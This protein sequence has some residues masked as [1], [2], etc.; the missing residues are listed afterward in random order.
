MQLIIIYV[1]RNSEETLFFLSYGHCIKTNKKITPSCLF[2]LQ[3][4]LTSG[5][6]HSFY[7]RN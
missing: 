3:P 1:N 7:Q 4:D 5:L 6:R 2:P